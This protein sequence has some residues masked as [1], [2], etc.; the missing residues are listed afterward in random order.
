M[1][2]FVKRRYGFLSRDHEQG[3][4]LER[5]LAAGVS[6]LLVKPLQSCDIAAAL[7]RVLHAVQ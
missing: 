2:A 1:S 4:K 5:A 6:E 7:A 3:L